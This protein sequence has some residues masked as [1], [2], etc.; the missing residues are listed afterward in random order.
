MA[1]TMVSEGHRLVPFK[2]NMYNN[3]SH[4]YLPNNFSFVHCTNNVLLTIMMRF[5][6]DWTE[7]CKGRGLESVK[8]QIIPVS[9]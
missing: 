5:N 6:S 9:S 3:L 8:S 4:N 2:N 7:S 1:S